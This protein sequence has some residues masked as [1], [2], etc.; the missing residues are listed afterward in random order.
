MALGVGVYA[1]SITT[2]TSLEA[3]SS[4]SVTTR[5]SRDATGKSSAEVNHH[6]HFSCVN[7]VELHRRHLADIDLLVAVGGDSTVL[8]AAH[9]MDRGT[10]PML[11]INP[12]PNELLRRRQQHRRG[13]LP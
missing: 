2:R 1:T 4:T 6:V 12:D 11:G 10:I 7:C 5:M 13:L 8:S 3:W 9:F